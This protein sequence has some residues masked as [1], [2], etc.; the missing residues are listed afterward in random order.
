MSLRDGRWRAVDLIPVAS[1]AGVGFIVTLNIRPEW[2]GGLLLVLEQSPV[3]WITTFLLTIMADNPGRSEGRRTRSQGATLEEKG[4]QVVDESL[5]PI[6]L[7]IPEDSEELEVDIREFFAEDNP[8]KTSGG[9]VGKWMRHSVPVDARDDT[10][11]DSE[12]DEEEDDGWRG[13]GQG[14]R[15]RGRVR[16]KG[17]FAGRG[18]N[19]AYEDGSGTGV[20]GRAKK[21]MRR[22]LQEAEMAYT[23][24]ANYKIR[25][26]ID[27]L[28]E[29]AM[30]DQSDHEM[31]DWET[32]LPDPGHT[33]G[34]MSLY[35][36]SL[37]V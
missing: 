13:G 32:Y 2:E 24:E 22:K 28:E 1:R 17:K 8:H 36:Q 16:G 33:R 5:P 26:I 21:D 14:R 31:A 29:E 6:Y 11:S 19:R 35:K 27:K 4:K 18:G 3:N 20:R 23:K 37:H 30:Q 25:R 15:G 12:N 10:E 7:D 9:K 34:R